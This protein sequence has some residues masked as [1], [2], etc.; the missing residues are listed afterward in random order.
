M[1][2]PTLSTPAARGHSKGIDRSAAL[3]PS[4]CCG[5]GKC[6]VGAC[7][8]FGGGCAGICVPNIGQC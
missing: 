4:D 1:R 5:A 7:L 6:C 2:L 3:V 8:P